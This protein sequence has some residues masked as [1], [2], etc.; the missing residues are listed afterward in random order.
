[1]SLFIRALASLEA[2]LNQPMLSLWRTVYFNFRTMLFRVVV[3]F[4]SLFM[5]G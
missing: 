4:R 1:M 3:K 2:R 5:D